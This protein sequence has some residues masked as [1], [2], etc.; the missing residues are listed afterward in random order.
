[1]LDS[2]FRPPK[3]PL[4]I[5]A[6]SSF[7]IFSANFHFDLSFIINLYTIDRLR[8]L[9]DSIFF[10]FEKKNHIALIEFRD[11]SSSK[12]DLIDLN[13]EFSDLCSNI[14]SEHEIFVLSIMGQGKNSFNFIQEYPGKY[15][16]KEI[17]DIGI[18]FI[19]ES[20]QTLE[21]PVI[22]GMHGNIIGQGLELALACDIRIATRDA[23]F[24][25]PHLGMGIMPFD[26]G[27][28]RLPRLIGR[29]MAL[30]I[31][32][33][34]DTFDAQAG[35]RMGIISRVVKEDDL[36]STVSSIA[37]EMTEKGPLALNYIKEAV[38]KGMDMTLDQ[39]LCLEADL[40]FLLHTTQDRREGIEAFRQKRKPFFRGE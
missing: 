14:S 40:Y 35:Y 31:M 5:L 19:S 21:I 12:F 11:F 25:L 34:G 28:Q 7:F 36:V 33:T 16:N 22:I 3:H 6:I 1:M 23:K 39:G 32:L 8:I 9:M 10:N 2:R 20:I 15:L 17:R 24:G 38:R 26:G 18:P 30:E 4:P 13:Y 37:E 27:T 29:S